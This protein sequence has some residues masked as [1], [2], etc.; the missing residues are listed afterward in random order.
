MCALLCATGTWAQTAPTEGVSASTG[1]YYLYNLGSGKYLNKGVAYGTHSDVDGAGAVI[2]ISGASDA[3]LLHFEGVDAQKYFGKDGYVDKAASDDN[4]TTWSFESAGEVSGY[5]NVYKLKANKTNSY[6]YWANATG[7]D[8]ANETWLSEDANGINAYWILI[9]KATRQAYAT[10]SLTNFIDATWRMKDPDFEGQNNGVGKS[11]STWDRN[12]FV[13]QSSSQ[14]QYSGMFA[15]KWAGS[16]NSDTGTQ[17]D[18]NYHLNN[19]TQ[20]QSLTDLP[21]GKY[22]LSATAEAVQQGNSENISGAYLFAGDQTTSVSTRG[23]YT[24]DF[25]AT[26]SPVT[27]GM[28]TESTTANWVSFDNVRLAYIDPAVSVVATD[29]ISGITMTADQWYSFTPAATDTYTFSATTGIIYTVDGTQLLSSATGTDLTTSL[30]LTA[31]TTYYFKS[32]SAQVLSVS[33][34][35]AY[36]TIDALTTAGWEEVTTTTELAD[37]NY[38]YVLYSVEGI[39][40]M[41]AEGVISGRQEG[42]NTMFYQYAADPTT[43]KTEVWEIVYDNTYKY[44]IRNLEKNTHYMQSRA[45]EPYKIQFKWETS[46]SKWT[47]FNFAYKDGVWTIENNA[48]DN[49]ITGDYFSNLYIGPW[50]SQSFFDGS[51]VAGNKEGANVGHFRIFRMARKYYNNPTLLANTQSIIANKGDITSMINGTFDENTTGWTGDNIFY[52]NDLKRNWRDG[53]TNNPFIERRNAGAMSY[54]L[55]NMPAG[56][57]KMVAAW[58]SCIGGTMTPAI[59]GTSGTTVTG[60][61]DIQAATSEINMNGV[62]MPYSSLGG[63]TTNANGHN[64]QWITAT[65]SL[66]SD[67]DLVLSFTTAGTDGW[68][69]IDDVHLYCTEL[70]GTSYTM[71]LPTIEANTGISVGDKVVTCDIVVSNPNAIISSDVAITGANGAINNNLVNGTINNL[72]L[73][74][75]YAYNAPDGEYAA[76]SATL[77]RNI[78]ASTWCTLTLPFVPETSLTQKVPSSLDNGTLNFEDATPANDTPM[79]VKSTGGVTAITGT[80]TS[81]ATGN[82]TSGT[83]VIMNGTYSSIEKV[84]QDCYI[85]A[86]AENATTD[87]LYK[88]DSDVSLAPFRAYFS[89]DETNS[90]SVKANVIR[91]SIDGNEEV[92]AIDGV[93]MP[94]TVASDAV[95]YDMSGRRFMNPSRGIYIVN[96]KK[97]LVK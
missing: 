53:S 71:T 60:V 86:R 94:E 81:G 61:G 84:T 49:D 55:S 38:Y 10:A 52:I 66:G 67:G 50:D 20:S 31:G 56:T 19:F 42:H 78:P 17:V 92:T 75:G 70:D 34:T 11:L 63:F 46:Q 44:G 79:L 3:Y 93:E 43:D 13:I 5:T 2:T 24:V 83:G 58:R 68:N 74:D 73:Y 91:I 32:S 47:I 12:D 51:A 62:Q 22:R 6:L 27:I 41:M 97:V 80:R 23:I 40:Q 95:F 16:S 1:D 69:A 89:I 64:W 76:T 14:S 25:T 35:T 45:G 21:L 30:E 54:T 59:A 88:V 72:V 48:C 90:Q 29:F 87:A 57:Y 9:P 36:T 65:G 7:K 4:Y 8:W 28:K 96:G 85:V 18:E 82:L 26:G 15:E 37:E 33:A 39:N 77:Y